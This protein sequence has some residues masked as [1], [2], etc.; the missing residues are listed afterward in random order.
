[1]EPF[2]YLT[3]FLLVAAASLLFRWL[4]TQVD[5]PPPAQRETAPWT[6]PD[7]PAKV[8]PARTPVAA[9]QAGSPGRLPPP[10]RHPARLA[11][12]GSLGDLRRGVLWMTI[13]GRCRGLEPPRRIAEVGTE[14]DPRARP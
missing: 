5:E 6:M 8:R 2:L 13:L 7:R 9:R 10:R 11:A 3:L 4:K 1:M 12:R 14:L